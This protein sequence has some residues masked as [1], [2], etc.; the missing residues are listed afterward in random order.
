[1]DSSTKNGEFLLIYCAVVPPPVAGWL[2]INAILAKKDQ[3]G[4]SEFRLD[5]PDGRELS[6]EFVKGA[7]VEDNIMAIRHPKPFKRSKCLMLRND[8]KLYYTKRK[9]PQPKPTNFVAR[10]PISSDEAIDKN[11]L[12]LSISMG[13]G[14]DRLQQF[15]QS[16]T[17]LA[18]SLTSFV[19]QTVDKNRQENR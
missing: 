8:G 19:A 7:L 9:S 5:S 4:K 16:P 11:L 3:E 2:R 18:N 10:M 15:L 13:I 1:M 12:A 17:P 6:A 14:M